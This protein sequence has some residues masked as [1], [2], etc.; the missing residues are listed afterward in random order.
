MDEPFAGVDAVTEKA[1]VSILRKMPDE[2]KTLIVV[3][4]DSASAREY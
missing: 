3:H 1:I 2:G 4:H